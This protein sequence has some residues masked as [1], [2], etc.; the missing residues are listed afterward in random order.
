R[1]RR[2]PIGPRPHEGALVSSLVRIAVPNKGRIRAPSIELLQATGLSFEASDRALPVRVCYAEIHLLFVRTA[3]APELGDERVAA[4]PNAA[5]LSKIE[6]FA[7]KRIATAHPGVTSRFFADAGIDVTVVPLRGSVEVA[8][9]L[10]V[11]DG[12]VD[13]VST[14]STLRVNGLREIGTL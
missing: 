4:L 7:G 8:T 5:D 1:R 6:D 14:G 10:G 13:L 12:I 2:I 9:K 3:D 11:A